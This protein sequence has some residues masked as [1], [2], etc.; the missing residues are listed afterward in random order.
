MQICLSGQ[1][2][3]RLLS[4]AGWPE[5]SWSAQFIWYLLTRNS[6]QLLWSVADVS[7]LWTSNWVSCTE[8]IK[9]FSRPTQLSTKFFLLIT[10]MSVGILIFINVK[11][12][13]LGLSEPQKIWIS[14]YFYFYEHITYH[15]QLSW[16]WKFFYN[17]G[18]RLLWVSFMGNVDLCV[19]FFP[20]WFWGW[21]VGL[22]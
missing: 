19:C 4:S 17:L 3:I 8:V 21:D 2:L 5:Q 6:A 7:E 22:N 12:S 1:R 16:A 20:F 9:L 18:P 10:F 15:A 13:I 11:N 14:W